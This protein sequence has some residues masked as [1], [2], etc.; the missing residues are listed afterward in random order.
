MIWAV[1][2]CRTCPVIQFW[3]LDPDNDPWTL[4]WCLPQKTPAYCDQLQIPQDYSKWKALYPHQRSSSQRQSEKKKTYSLRSYT[5]PTSWY[6]SPEGTRLL[7]H[8]TQK[9]S[10]TPI[11]HLDST[12]HQRSRKNTQAPQDQSPLNR[13]SLQRLKILAADRVVWREEVTRSKDRNI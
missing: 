10:R 7:F 5:T 9:T 1:Q 2:L 3:D 12:S 13:N 8:P 11:P 4:S 6:T